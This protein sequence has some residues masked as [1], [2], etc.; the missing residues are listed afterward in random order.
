MRNPQK[1]NLFEDPDVAGKLKTYSVIFFLNRGCGFNLKVVES[2]GSGVRT[3]FHMP[4][5]H[6]V[7]HLR[8]P[9]VLRQRSDLIFE[10]LVLFLHRNRLGEPFLFALRREVGQRRLTPHQ[11]AERQ[12]RPILRR[13]TLR[14]ETKRVHLARLHRNPLRKID[15]F[16]Y[17]SDLQTLAAM[18]G[19]AGD[20]FCTFAAVDPVLRQPLFERTVL[21]D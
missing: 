20:H 14:I 4:V 15:G 19:I 13:G 9:P 7:F 21:Q 8:S 10:G 17:R 18:A 1:K 5:E 11:D 3:R 16:V 2:N 6:Q 12:L